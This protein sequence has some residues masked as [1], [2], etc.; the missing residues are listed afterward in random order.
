MK[1]CS[2]CIM[3]D[4]ASGIKLNEKGLCQLCADYKEYTPKGEETLRNEIEGYFDRNAEVNCIV[5]VSGGRDS[6]YALYYAKAV[7]GLKPIAVHNDNDF[8]TEIATRNL[9]VMTKRLG[10]S[11]LRI[12]SKNKI[13]KEITLEKFKMNAPF[14]PGLVVEQT[15]E[16][17]EYGFLSAAYSTAK[18]RGIKIVIWGDSKDESTKSFHSLFPHV[19]PSKW[20]RL[21]SGRAL[22]L[23]SYKR[24][25]KQMQ[26]ECGS[27]APQGL[28]VIHLYDYIMWDRRIIVNT[29]QE[30]MGWSAPVDSPTTWRVDCSLVPLVNYLTERAY[31]VSKIEVGFSS[32]VRN[33]KMEREEAIKQVELVKKN[34]HV[35]AL[36]LFL[37]DLGIPESLINKVF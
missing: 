36:R 35:P 17:C 26:K 5:P 23:I 25:Y 31:G 16:A 9:D 1:R 10:V 24:L 29:I 32:M 21:L 18:K 30:K 2:K 3:P 37:S 12:S 6:A 7:L 28:K 11:L 8:E 14:G 19:F 13:F 20:Q 4:T 33:G 27:N 22:N 15:C 34:T